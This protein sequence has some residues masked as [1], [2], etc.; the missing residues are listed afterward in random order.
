MKKR[1]FLLPGFG[2][3]AFCFDEI[4]PYLDKF[5]LINVEYR[6]TLNKFIFPFINVRKFAGQL[7]R[8]FDIRSEDK[9]IG[10]SMGGYFSFQIREIQDN[11][12]CMISSFNDPKKTY[13]IFPEFPRFTQFATLSGLVKLPLISKYLLDKIKDEKIRVIQEKVMQN[14]KTFNNFQLALM[15]EMIYEPKINSSKPNPLRIHA[16]KDRVIMPPDEP[17]IEIG[18]GHFCQ[19]LYP[20]ETMAA[21]EVFLY[22]S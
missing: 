2:E 5:E 19:N 10:H 7:I 17:F 12:I 14:F 15:A 9:L 8:D 20:K 4:R 6:R 11:E 13:H 22:S 16:L 3:D 1:I 18:G 21:M